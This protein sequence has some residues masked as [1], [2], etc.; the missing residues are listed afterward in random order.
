MNTNPAVWETEPM[1]DVGLDIYYAA[2]PTYPIK[3]KRWRSDKLTPD[4]IDYHWNPEGGI[5]TESYLHDYGWRGEEVIP[6]GAKIVGS[7]ISPRI[8]FSSSLK[9][10][11]P[12]V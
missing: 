6:V 3:L 1:E 2:S 10:F 12:L 9:S 8:N 4:P 11:L 5:E 7:V